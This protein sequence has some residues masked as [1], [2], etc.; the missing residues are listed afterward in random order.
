M[1]I[2]EWQQE[3]DS[4]ISNHGVR[5]FDVKTNTIIL[6]EEVGELARLIA[7]MYGE[8]SFKQSISDQEQT[9]MLSEELGDVIFVLTCIANQTGIDLEKIL[10]DNLEKKTLRDRERHHNNPKLSEQ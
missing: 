6:M 5:Y 10:S 1:N 9:N 4:W 3:V 8:Q 2:N 7:R